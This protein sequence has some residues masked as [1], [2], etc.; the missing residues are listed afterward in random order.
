MTLPVRSNGDYAVGGFTYVAERA[1][2]VTARLGVARAELSLR[3]GQA[4]VYFPATGTG[5]AMTL[6][7]ADPSLELFVTGV[8]LG[9]PVP[10]TTP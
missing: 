2:A 10:N 7:L 4:R 3:A 1:T 9:I 5:A 6:T 8:V